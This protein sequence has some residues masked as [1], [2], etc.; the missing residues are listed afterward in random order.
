MRWILK[1]LVTLGSY[2]LA[3]DILY[4]DCGK[5]K[6]KKNSVQ[7]L[8][9][10]DEFLKLKKCDFIKIDVELMEIE[11]L[12][13]AKKFIKKYKPFLWIENHWKFPNKINQ[14]LIEIG[15]IPYWC[16]KKIYNPNNHF[17]NEI[18]LYFKLHTIN[19]LAIPNTKTIDYNFLV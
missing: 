5:I 4:S 9:L 6:F 1:K 14:F 15:Y 19:T 7:I 13:G 12:K 11:V 8:K 10:D 17:V 18:D 3:Q 16:V 2:P